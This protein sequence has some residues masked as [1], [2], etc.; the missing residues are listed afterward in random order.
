[1]LCCPQSGQHS[2]LGFGFD[3]DHLLISIYL[4]YL[5]SISKHLVAYYQAIGP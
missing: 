4:V 5:L 1:M 2:I 3:Y